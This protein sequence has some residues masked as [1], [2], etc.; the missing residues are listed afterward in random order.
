MKFKDFWALNFETIKGKTAHNWIDIKEEVYLLPTYAVVTPQN[1]P[2]E[3][4]L[5]AHRATTNVLPLRGYKV[6]QE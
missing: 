3:L 5:E 4:S 1:T 6:L 2:T